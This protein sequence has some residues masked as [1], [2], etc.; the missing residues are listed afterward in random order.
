MPRSEIV[1]AHQNSGCSTRNDPA[2]G[3]GA[4][5]GKEGPER[6]VDR[7]DMDEQI[8]AFRRSLRHLAEPHYS[9]SHLLAPSLLSFGLLLWLTT[10]DQISA[11]PASRSAIRAP[12]F[13]S[14]PRKRSRVGALSRLFPNQVVTVSLPVTGQA[15]SA[16]L[17]CAC[18]VPDVAASM[19]RKSNVRTIVIGI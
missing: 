19:A 17:L 15:A 14:L 11:M 6:S 1:R 12:D 4:G 9:T 13:S 16:Q 3:I 5:Q 7:S 18:G 8:E 2:A 10:T